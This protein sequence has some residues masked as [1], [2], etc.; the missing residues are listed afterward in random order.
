VAAKQ[1]KNETNTYERR[2]TDAMAKGELKVSYE[3]DGGLLYH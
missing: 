1:N 3:D 2:D